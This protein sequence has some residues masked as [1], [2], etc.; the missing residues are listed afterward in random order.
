MR[1][2]DLHAYIDGQLD[3]ARR[4]E[5]ETWLAEDEEAARRVEAYRTQNALLHSLFD[6]V[7]KEPLSG[8]LGELAEHLGARIAAAGARR[9]W[10]TQP[11]WQRLAASIAFVAVGLGVGWLGHGQW[12]AVPTLQAERPS[13][14]SF[15]EEA[16]QA[17]TFYAHSRFEV[18]MGADDQEALNNWLSER[19]GRAVFGPD[20]TMVGYRLKGG[21]SLPTDTGTVAQYMYESDDANRL[22]LFVGVPQAAGQQ[23]AFSFVKRGDIASFYWA[24]GSLSYALVGRFERDR[25]MN[26]AQTVHQRLKS[27]PVPRQVNPQNQ[28][29][30]S[31]KP[32]PTPADQVPPSPANDQSRP[33]SS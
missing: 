21:R 22:T 20:L 8:E 11:G 9:H 19:L 24:E 29:G 30:Q 10:W 3:P 4:I 14:L 15:A 27:G 1:D 32:V 6:P 7:L 2:S 17:H 13:L 26:I 25:L 5:V 18:E 31:S 12:A 33:K 16:A 23:A 28:S